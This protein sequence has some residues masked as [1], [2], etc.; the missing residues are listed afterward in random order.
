MSVVHSL[1]KDPSALLMCVS[2][3]QM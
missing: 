3:E 2:Q 1:H